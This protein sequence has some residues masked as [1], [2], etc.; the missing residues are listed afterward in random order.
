[1]YDEHWSEN[2]VRTTETPRPS[3]PNGPLWHI[4]WRKAVAQHP[5]EDR[6]QTAR[7]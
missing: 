6:S 3:M 5:T 4:N 2:R 1:M 7:S